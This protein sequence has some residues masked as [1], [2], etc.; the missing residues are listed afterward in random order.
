MSAGTKFCNAAGNKGNCRR[1]PYAQA[2]DTNPC[3]ISLGRGSE[4][5]ENPLYRALRL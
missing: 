3:A 4:Q 2:P 5:Q 1:K